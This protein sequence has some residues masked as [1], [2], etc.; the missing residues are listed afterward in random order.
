MWDKYDVDDSGDL[1]Q[2]ETRK[3]VQDMMGNLGSA[4]ELSDEDF[5]RVF[6]TFDEDDSGTIEREEMVT[7]IKQLLLGVECSHQHL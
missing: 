5:D 3:F 4:E 2:Q 6:A 7:F 1:D